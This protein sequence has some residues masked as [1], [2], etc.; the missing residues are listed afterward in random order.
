[1]TTKGDGLFE[2]LDP[3]PGGLP[4]LRE[5]LEGDVRWRR[6][7]RPALGVSAGLLVVVLVGW[8]VS[9]PSEEQDIPPEFD[10]VRI[11]LGQ[12]SAPS[13]T[14]TIS[15]PLSGQTAVRR[16]PLETD[17]VVFYLIDSVE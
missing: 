17:D 14:L 2:T 8:V 13:E 6:R 9:L 12:L 4:K 11:H 5:R 16:V 15:D 10:L 7:G 1:M 3:P